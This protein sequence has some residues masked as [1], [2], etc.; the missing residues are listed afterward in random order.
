MET[1]NKL[2]RSGILPLLPASMVVPPIRKLIL[3]SKNI[4][5]IRAG[6]VNEKEAV[7]RSYALTGVGTPLELEIP[8]PVA[9]V[10]CFQMTI[11]SIS[12]FS[13]A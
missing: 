3:G 5:P 9:A 4:V 13:P 8:T 11:S 1:G 10:T 6:K 2:L 7:F 12:S